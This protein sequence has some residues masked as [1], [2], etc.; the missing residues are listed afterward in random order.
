MPELLILS[1]LL[2]VLT[3]GGFI[4]DYIFPHIRPLN[5]FIES[6]PMME[7]DFDES[8]VSRKENAA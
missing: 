1:G 8:E 6:L 7:D 3:I 4:A 2:C 5:R